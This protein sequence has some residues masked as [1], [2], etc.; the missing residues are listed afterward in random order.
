MLQ[1]GAAMLR[2]L[3][4]NEYLR[5]LPLF[6]LC[7]GTDPEFEA[8]YYGTKERPGTVSANRIAVLEEDGAILSMVH[9]KPLLA[10]YAPDPRGG[11]KAGTVPVTYLM[12]VATHPEHRH[13]GHM[14]S[15]MRFAMDRLRKEGEPWCF[16]V[17]VDKEIYRHLG[18]TCDWPF[19]ETERDLLAAD[20]GLTDCS[21]CPLTAG[22]FLPPRRV[23]DRG[24]CPHGSTPC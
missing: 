14:D 18:F 7:F 17:A 1:K 20:D 13:A 12:C 24:D 15:V 5:T 23:F 19:N 11:G 16:L 6:R 9:L 22:R 4:K 3:E 10:E 21:A 2:F 8:E